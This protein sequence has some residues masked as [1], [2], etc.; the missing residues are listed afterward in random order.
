MLTMFV[1]GL[2][3]ALLLPA[4]HVEA[5]PAARQALRCTISSFTNVVVLPG[6]TVT[7]EKVTSISEGGSYQESSNLGFPQKIDK[8]PAL[9]AVTVRVTNTSD[10]PSRPQ[11]SYRFG[12][13]LPIASKY[14]SRIF[15]VGSAAFAGGINWPSMSEGT[16][17]GFAA[18]S[19][20]N[21]HNSAGSDMSW[22][23]PASLWDWGY[24]ALHGSVVAG[25]VL[26]EHYYGK[27]I[28][29]SYYAGCSTGGRQGLR[30]IQYDAN[31]FDGALIGAP[32]WD[33]VHLMPWI[34]KMA[35]YQL[36][37]S[38]GRLGT[39]QMSILAAEVVKQCDPQDGIVDNV[40][41]QPSTCNFDISTITC[42]DPSRCLT[43]AQAQTAM[44]I[45]ADYKHPS[46]GRLI[47]NGFTLASED[48]WYVYYGDDATLTDFDFAFPRYFLYNLSS[49]NFAWQNYTD[50]VALDSERINPGAATANKFDVS[51]KVQET[52]TPGKIIMYHGLADGVLSPKTSQLYYNS[53]IQAMGSSLTETQKWFRYFE[54]P[55]MQHC[56]FS[57]RQNA[58]WD[59]AAPGQ[60]SWLRM[61]P[62]LGVGLPAV[63]DGWSVPGH[64]NDSDYDILAALIKWVEEDKP[65][66][67]VIG[68]AFN[69]DFS[70]YRTRPICVWPK[71][72]V[73]SG[74]GNVN[75]ASTWRCQ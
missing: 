56:M 49:T 6:V 1:S 38:S 47:S 54:I 60:P 41:S 66:E 64:L 39:N 17:Y 57:N 40:V 71:K 35:V 24:R 46:S 48:Q 30:E 25:R 29:R 14:N 42:N 9:C 50:S 8:L 22:A 61:L 12:L 70:V 37:S 68:T 3:L 11:S 27:P 73:Y 18:I 51:P 20:D 45:Y 26:I 62:S 19:T 2:L 53:T 13:F 67:R 7:I 28:V 43:A 16:H 36:Q 44:R 4:G 33:T 72:A 15:T 34:S 5:V 75:N 59:I 31:T 21:G 65:V 10:T 23:T 32:A 58:P 74:S 52:K 69:S 63:G 55:G